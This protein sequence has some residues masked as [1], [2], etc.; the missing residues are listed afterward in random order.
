M[1]VAI[2]LKSSSVE[3]RRPQPAQLSFNEISLNYN[4]AGPFICCKDSSGKIVQLGGVKFNA[5][6][7]ADALPGTWWWNTGTKTLYVWD[8]LIWNEVGGQSG[9][10]TGITQILGDDGID[11]F[12]NGSVVTLNVDADSNKG[13]HFLADRLAINVGANLSFDSEGRL[14][15]DILSVSYKGTLDLANDPVVSNPNLNDAYINTVVGTLNAAWQAATGEGAVAVKSGDAVIYGPSGWS[16]IPASATPT[17]LGVNGRT[18]TQLNIT[19]S[20]GSNAALLAATDLL[21]G[22]MTAGDKDKL[23]DIEDGAQVNVNS[24]WVATTGDAEI[25]NKPTIP[26]AQ[27]NSDWSATSGIAQILNKPSVID[28]DAPSDGKNYGRKD[29]AWS[30]IEPGGVTQ[31]SAGTNVTISPVG[32][33]GAVTVNT[34]IGEAPNDGLQYARQSEAWT[35]VTGAIAIVDTTSINTNF[36]ISPDTG[37]MFIGFINANRT[38]TDDMDSGESITMMVRRSNAAY[39]ITWPS[40]KWVGGSQPILPS[41]TGAY[42]IITVWKAGT[43]LFGSYGG[44]A[45]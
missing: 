25:L 36:A 30:E 31:I 37:T 44:D 34:D 39:S 5:D 29:A 24:D 9:G 17:D 26:A 43:T 18:A 10:G 28:G 7:P 4:E 22:L 12:V 16:F 21:A 2:I 42:A 19:S 11:A 33:T 32:G 40:I 3:D 23:D 41:A 14:K 45:S 6:V 38:Y 1:A 20:T 35:E 8:G 13:L 27:V 15:A